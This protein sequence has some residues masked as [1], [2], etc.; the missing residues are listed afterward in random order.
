M[1]H[2][3]SSGLFLYRNKSNIPENPKAAANEPLHLPIFRFNP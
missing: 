2:G 1:G 3:L